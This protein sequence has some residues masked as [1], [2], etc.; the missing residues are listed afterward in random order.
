MFLFDLEAFETGNLRGRLSA[1][2]EPG[3][4]FHQQN[5]EF[6]YTYNGTM[7]KTA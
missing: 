2:P 6:L 4:N 7:E 1:D 3:T 5:S